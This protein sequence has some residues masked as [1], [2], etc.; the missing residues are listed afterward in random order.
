M[1]DEQ[2]AG[3]GPGEGEIEA[4]A[5]GPLY[6]AS[7]KFRLAPDD[8]KTFGDAIGAAIGRELARGSVE[9][10]R[11]TSCGQLLEPHEVDGRDGHARAA[12]DEDG[13]LECVHCGP[14]VPLGRVGRPS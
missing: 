9:A 1:S 4:A 3:L 6:H 7:A 8:L 10:Y 14:A 13:G 11:C 2:K 12:V 5:V